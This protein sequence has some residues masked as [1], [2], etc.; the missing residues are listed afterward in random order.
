M[1]EELPSLVLVQIVHFLNLRDVLLFRLIS[2][3][4]FE[5]SDDVHFKKLNNFNTIVLFRR[6]F[7]DIDDF[8]GSID[9]NIANVQSSLFGSF[10]IKCCKTSTLVF[11][12]FQKKILNLGYHFALASFMA[13]SSRDFTYFPIEES[14][15]DRSI[16]INNSSSNWF[17]M[18]MHKQKIDIKLNY[19][20][21]PVEF[22]SLFSSFKPPKTIISRLWSSTIFFQKSP[23]HYYFLQN[24]TQGQMEL[25]LTEFNKD[26][27]SLTTWT[28]QNV[29]HNSSTLLTLQNEYNPIMFQYQQSQITA[30]ILG[31]NSKNVLLCKIWIKNKDDYQ[32]IAIDT[33]IPENRLIYF[34]LYKIDG[35]GLPDNTVDVYSLNPQTKTL[36]KFH[37]IPYSH[38]IHLWDHYT[39]KLAGK[40]KFS[41]LDQNMAKEVT[42]QEFFEIEY[43]DCQPN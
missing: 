27:D 17:C 6:L 34:G 39:I 36:I 24:K 18:I 5:I 26:G 16:L 13:T 10:Q 11:L 1:L 3:T 7:V 33:K 12:Q 4:T 41:H 29:F 19:V 38:K 20:F 9:C 42:H 21:H 37:D 23:N 22:L 15:A 25:V 28:F 14:V 30:L 40:L 2:R 8:F 43:L 31:E 32:L 35:R